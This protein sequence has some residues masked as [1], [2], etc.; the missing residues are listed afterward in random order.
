MRQVTFEEDCE[1]LVCVLPVGQSAK[2]HHKLDLELQ[3]LIWQ[4]RNG[5]LGEDVPK[6]LRVAIQ[7]RKALYQRAQHTRIVLKTVPTCSLNQHYILH[8]LPKD[9]RPLP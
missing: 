3:R 2:S 5:H 6:G 9:R 1:G 4:E 8:F 7:L